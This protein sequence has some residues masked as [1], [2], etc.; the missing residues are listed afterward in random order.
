MRPV[1]SKNYL[2]QDI[3]VFKKNVLKYIRRGKSILQIVKLESM[4]DDNFIYKMLDKDKQFKDDYVQARQDQALFYA[5]KIESTIH[6]LKSLDADKKDRNTID[7]ARLE[8]DSL[9]WIASKLLPKTYGSAQNVNNI[10]VN[11]TPVEGMQIYDGT[12]KTESSE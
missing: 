6:D 9:K 7:I 5:E 3:N 2:P 12:I 8:V 4:P 10:Q 11:L 1:G